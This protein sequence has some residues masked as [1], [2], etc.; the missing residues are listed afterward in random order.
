MQNGING[1]DLRKVGIIATVFS[2]VGGLLAVFLMPAACGAIVGLWTVF[3]GLLF[4]VGLFLIAIGDI[5]HRRSA[6]RSM[7][8]TKASVGAIFG[9]AIIAPSL[10]AVLF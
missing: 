4:I 2:L 1:S 7:L 8:R 10:I 9:I 3:F 5:I 6:Y